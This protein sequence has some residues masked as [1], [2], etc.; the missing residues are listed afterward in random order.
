MALLI[1]F[2]NLVRGLAGSA[3]KDRVADILEPGFLFNLAEEY[4]RVVVARAYADWRM[5]DVNQFQYELYNLG[6]DL[7]HVLAKRQKNAVDVKLAVDAIEMSWELP[8]VTTYVL[9]T[10]DRDFIH[11]LKALRRRCK[12]IVGVAPDASVSDDF[13]T[14]CDRFI[15]YTALCSAYAADSPAPVEPSGEVPDLK[16]V[17]AVLRQA[18]VR[19]PEGLKGAQVVP[20]LRREISPTFD[21]SNYGFSKLTQLLAALPEV[22]R[23]VPGKD[24][25]DILVLE[26][27]P[28]KGRAARVPAPERPDPVEE[29]I[30]RG[31]LNTYRYERNAA[32]RRRILA[33]L[34][35]GMCR[36][37]VFSLN[38]VAKRI[39]EETHDSKLSSALLTNYQTVLWQSKSFTLEPDQGAF[40]LRE[41]ILRLRPDL[42][43][44]DTFVAS[45]ERSIL[46]KARQA[47][48]GLDRSLAARLLGLRTDDPSDLEYCH[49]LLTEAEARN[50]CAASNAPPAEPQ[51]A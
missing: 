12:I 25:G 13:A 23:V 2:E 37:E 36:R 31:G 50:G 6:V 20:I 41:R 40:P 16:R 47:E 1:D 18:L 48:P 30:R 9:V 19:S 32:S 35:R 21:V 15:K 10:G 8:A 17:A 29:L 24:G 51:L 39:A 7:I 33:E 3:G 4:G 44:P 14:L 34:H 27:K 42:L 45:Y 5:G 26:A 28:P 11:V 46:Y 43:D 38:H 49:R 22:A